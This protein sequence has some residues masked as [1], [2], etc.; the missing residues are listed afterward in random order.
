MRWGATY[1]SGAAVAG[2]AGAVA[3]ATLAIGATDILA[4]GGRLS[5]LDVLVG[6]LGQGSKDVPGLQVGNG[7]AA[8]EPGHALGTI[9]VGRGDG[10]SRAGCDQRREAH[11]GEE[12]RSQSGVSN[13]GVGIAMQASRKSE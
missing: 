8:K 10:G 12:R 11:F 13:K 9:A 6:D 2:V 4:F 5:T 3:G 7:V 1:S